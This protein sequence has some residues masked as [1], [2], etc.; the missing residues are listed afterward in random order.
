MIIV[1]IL[2]GIFVLLVLVSVCIIIWFIGLLH[3][4]GY[5]ELF[6]QRE[7]ELEIEKEKKNKNGKEN[8]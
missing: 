6:L 5:L 4:T 2:V 1:E 3:K 8:G 7:L